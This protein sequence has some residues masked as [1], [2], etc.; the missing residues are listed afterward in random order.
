MNSHR[1]WH[2]IYPTC[3][4]NLHL[5]CSSFQHGRRTS[6]SNALKLEVGADWLI[7]LPSAKRVEHSKIST[8][9]VLKNDD[10]LVSMIKLE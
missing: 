7:A 1:Q 2:V 5:R 8:N 10:D 6:A 3:M 9:K 4:A